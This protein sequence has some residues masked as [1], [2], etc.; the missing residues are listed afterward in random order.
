[1]TRKFPRL[2]YQLLLHVYLASVTPP[3]QA[4][5][6][7]WLRWAAGKIS[8]MCLSSVSYYGICALLKELFVSTLA[9][10]NHTRKHYAVRSSMSLVC[11]K[12]IVKKC[13]KETF[14]QTFCFL[15]PLKNM[16]GGFGFSFSHHNGCSL[17]HEAGAFISVTKDVAAL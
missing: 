14:L 8:W 7:K 3:L 10:L 5:D 15:P 13:P 16:S 11:F 9:V 6:G 17:R 4:S 2:C 1:M 12:I